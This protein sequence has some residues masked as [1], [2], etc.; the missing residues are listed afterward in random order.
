VVPQWQEEAVMFTVE[1]GKVV[2][3][4]AVN[5]EFWTNV[6]VGIAAVMGGIMMGVTYIKNKY[7]KMKTEE[8]ILDVISP[9]EIKHNNIYDMLV[10]LRIQM[11]ADRA[12]IAQFHN[13]GKFLEGS[14]MKRFSV[15]HETCNPGVSMEYPFLQAVL[16]TLFSD[17][18]QMLK[19]NDSKIRFTRSLPVESAL[20]TYNDSKNIQAFSVLP[21]RKGELYVGFIRLEWNDIMMLPDDPDDAKRLMEQYRSFIELE[22][23]R[24]NN[25][26]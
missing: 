24:K 7:A 10:S 15:T 26:K 20:K 3:L 19:Q 8:E 16:T 6:G 12:Q 21:I 17:M 2:I 25:G 13:G 1:E 14:P 5:L 9:S 23:L 11:S 4:S 18:I 22:M